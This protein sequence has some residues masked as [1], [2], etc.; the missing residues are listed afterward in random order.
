MVKHMISTWV[1]CSILSV[2][3]LFIY[4]FFIYIY[5]YIYIFWGRDRGETRKLI[6]KKKMLFIKEK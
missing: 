1:V 5:I 6:D 4:L 2:L 3:G